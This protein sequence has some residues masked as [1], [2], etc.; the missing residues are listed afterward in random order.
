M[1][2]RIAL[3][4]ALTHLVLVACG[5]SHFYFWN[6]GSVGRVLD[7]YGILSGAGNSYPFFAPVVGTSIRAQFDL[8]DK[9][10]KKIGEDDLMNGAT[11]EINLRISNI[12]EMIDEDITQE[13]TRHLLAASWV[14][15]IFARH[16]EASK[17]TLRVET[18][19]LPPMEEYKK[20][21]RYDWE[22]IYTASFA[23]KGV[24]HVEAD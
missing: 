8:F 21:E 16:P 9:N 4:L 2:K 24:P 3:I 15:K 7:R 10:G 18:F 19:D 5:A 20:G 11:R 13:E 23:K 12:V 6:F 17:V 22:Q 1:K 14:G